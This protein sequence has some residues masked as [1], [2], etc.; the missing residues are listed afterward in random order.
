[1]TS[2]TQIHP[3]SVGAAWFG[4]LTALGA[5]LAASVRFVLAL[6]ERAQQRARLAELDAASL[7]DMGLTQGDVMRELQ[8]SALWR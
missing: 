5:A 2:S 1:M 3:L 7:K 6:Q 8:K 4:V